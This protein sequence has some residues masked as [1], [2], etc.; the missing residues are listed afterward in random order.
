MRTA[1]FLVCCVLA[2]RLDAATPQPSD[3]QKIILTYPNNGETF[4]VND[5]VTVKWLCLDDIMFVDIRLSPDGGKTWIL[6]NAESIAYYDTA[7]WSHFKWVIPEKIKDKTKPNASEFT[8]AGNNE[9]LFRVENYSPNDRTEISISAKPMIILARSGVIVLD[10]CAARKPVFNLNAILSRS[11]FM[12]DGYSSVRFF[13]TR[14]RANFVSKGMSSGLI[15]GVISNGA[16]P[17]QGA[18]KAAYVN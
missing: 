3:S 2:F 15:V 8:L 17:I 12:V 16:L 6:L 13:D 5:T 14:G 7:R 11:S 9:C 18:Q 1:L 4:R 10:R